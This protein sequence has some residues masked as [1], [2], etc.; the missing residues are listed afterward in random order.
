[1]IPPVDRIRAIIGLGNPGARFVFHRHNI[2]FRIVDRF[3][4]QYNEAWHERDK[5]MYAEVR[6]TNA[7]Q[8]NDCRLADI[9]YGVKPLTYMNKSGEVLNFL[10][11][12]GI[13]PHEILVAHDELE[14]KFGNISIA[15]GGSARGHN[16]LRSIMDT[17]GQDFWRLRFGIG[18]P[19][20][21]E[22]VGDY[23]LSNFTIEEASVLEESIQFAV[24][25]LHGKF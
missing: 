3:V 9:V 11:K 12:K 8:H 21:K 2:G 13:K 18:R 19:E 14:R 7:P 24:Q 15:F 20:N 1:M 4:E 23:V 17:I 10:Q 6:T 5:L 16:G 22:D 25:L